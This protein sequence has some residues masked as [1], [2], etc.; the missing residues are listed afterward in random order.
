[1]RESD[2]FMAILDEG[3]AI[4]TRRSIRR[5]ASR[6]LGEPDK[7]IVDHLKWITDIDHLERIVVRAMEASSWQ[8]LLDTR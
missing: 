4:Q 7:A 5:L 8:D 1:V 6:M 3:R 2:T